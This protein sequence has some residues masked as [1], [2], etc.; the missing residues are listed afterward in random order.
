MI[1]YSLTDILLL[2]FFPDDINHERYTCDCNG[3]GNA[4]SLYKGVDCDEKRDFCKESYGPCQ[5]GA[6]CISDDLTFVS[7]RVGRPFPGSTY[8]FFLIFSPF[9]K[10]QFSFY[11]RPNFIFS[12]LSLI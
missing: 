4:E 3:N 1:I 11:E 12:Q 2:L 6:T 7:Q 9:S 5:N 10:L 8:I